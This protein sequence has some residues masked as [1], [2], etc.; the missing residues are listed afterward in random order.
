MK[1][2]FIQVLF[3]AA[4]AAGV[5]AQVPDAWYSRGIG[6]GGAL[7][8]PSINPAD[9]NE[10]YLGCDMSALYHSTNLGYSW[11]ELSFLQIQGGHDACVQF[12]NNQQ[13][14]YCVDYSTIQGNDCIRS[15][16]EMDSSGNDK[17]R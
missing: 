1:R 16:Q 2:L 6:G 13:L 3:L 17:F 4:A 14:R 9:H 11:Q 7:F 12:T 10:I 8:S 5:M 15:A